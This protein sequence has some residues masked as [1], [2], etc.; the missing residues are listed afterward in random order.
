M[1]DKTSVRVYI[2][3]ALIPLTWWGA[4]L[5]NAALEP[6]TVDMPDWSFA[7]MPRQFGNWQGEDTEL[8][9]LIAVATGA[10]TIVNRCYRDSAGHVINMH[11]AVFAD[12]KGGVYHSP[13]N[14]YRSQGWEKLSE[15]HTDLQVND[16]LSIPVDVTLWDH[17]GE[18]RIVV[19]WY[20]LGQHVLFGR[21]DLGIKVRWSLA[22]KPTWPA[23]IKV[24]LEIP[25]SQSDDAKTVVLN[26]A[27][28]VAKW[29]NQPGHRNGKGMLGTQNTAVESKSAAPP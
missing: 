24:M 9:P 5:M 12:P 7:E 22:G 21:W 14:C 19:Y 18:R 27:E 8:D 13:I 4:R 20:Q 15:V 16:E 17:N 26:F 10:Q 29:A 25:T 2:V 11:T 1:T 6:P 23:L 28:Q 3:V